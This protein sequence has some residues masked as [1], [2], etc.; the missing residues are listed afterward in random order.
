L[1]GVK[2]EDNFAERDEERGF[3]TFVEVVELLAAVVGEITSTGGGATK[4]AERGAAKP[5]EEV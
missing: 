1:T 5:A 3:G 4:S 2:K